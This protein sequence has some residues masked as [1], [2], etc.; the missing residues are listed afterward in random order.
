MADHGYRAVL[1]HLRTSR[2]RLAQ[3][4]VPWD[5]GPDTWTG[6]QLGAVIAFAAAWQQM[7]LAVRDH[8][9]YRQP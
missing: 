7:H 3:A 2:T 9:P 8:Q 5:D 1:A 4:R 6:E